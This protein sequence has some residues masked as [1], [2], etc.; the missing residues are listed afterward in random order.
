LY[1]FINN[2]LNIYNITARVTYFAFYCPNIGVFS[3]TRKTQPMLLRIGNQ[4]RLPLQFPRCFPRK[5]Y[6]ERRRS[7]LQV[8]CGISDGDVSENWIFRIPCRDSSGS[9]N[10]GASNAETLFQRDAICKIYAFK[11]YNLNIPTKRFFQNTEDIFF[12]RYR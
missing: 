12:S 9:V 3:K 7:S 4:S 2:S 10:Y 1:N 6:W 8:I 11:I 5:T